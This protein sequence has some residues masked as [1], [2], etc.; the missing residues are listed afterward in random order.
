VAMFQ[1]LATEAFRWVSQPSF[2]GEYPF[3]TPGKID[4]PLRL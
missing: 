3:R 4:K 2:G 1:R